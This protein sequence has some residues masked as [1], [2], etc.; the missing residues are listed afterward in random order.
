MQAFRKTRQYSSAINI[1]TKSLVDL[2]IDPEYKASFSVLQLSEL[3]DFAL[4]PILS[5]SYYSR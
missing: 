4:E 1:N 2:K 5:I 3:W